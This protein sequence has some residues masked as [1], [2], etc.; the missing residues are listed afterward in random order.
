MAGLM[1]R[2]ANVRA[3]MGQTKTAVE[4]LAC[5]LADPVVEQKMINETETVGDLAWKSLDALRTA[6]DAEI[7]E[8]AR[9]RGAGKSLALGVRELLPG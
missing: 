2:I 8:T 6:L 3:E 5:V 1:T 9:V 4:I 7:F